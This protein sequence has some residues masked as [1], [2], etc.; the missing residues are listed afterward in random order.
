MMLMGFKWI[1]MTGTKR[2]KRRK[3][4]YNRFFFI[5]ISYSP[6]WIN[7]LK[8]QANLIK[9]VSNQLRVE[10]KLPKVKK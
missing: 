2:A 4:L 9:A 10:G 7:G 1:L 5:A 6:T 3:F 8:A